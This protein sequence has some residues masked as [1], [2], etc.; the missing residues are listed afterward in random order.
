MGHWVGIG[1]TGDERWSGDA[2][3]PTM[4]AASSNEGNIQRSPEMDERGG[5]VWVRN[6]GAHRYWSVNPGFE[7]ALKG[8]KG[9]VGVSTGAGYAYSGTLGALFGAGSSEAKVVHVYDPWI[10]NPSDPGA[11]HG[12]MAN[13]PIFR[14][15]AFIRTTSTGHAGSFTLRAKSKIIVYDDSSTKRSTNATEDPNWSVWSTVATCTPTSGWSS[16]L[17]TKAY[18]LD[19]TTPGG[20]DHYEAI[21]LKLRIDNYYEYAVRVDE[22]GI[23]GGV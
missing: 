12:G 11:I 3:M 20:V 14:F 6:D 21:K 19:H 23:Y 4:T 2:E 18:T 5:A 22:A 10:A 1:H 8:W 16:C 15:H 17:G 9:T 13:T 7:E